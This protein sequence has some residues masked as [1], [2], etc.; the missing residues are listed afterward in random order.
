MKILS[1]DKK[2]KDYYYLKDE[3][4]NSYKLNIIFYDL[5]IEVN[6]GDIICINENYLNDKVLYFGSIKEE[7]G[8]RITRENVYDEIIVIQKGNEK[9]FLKRFYG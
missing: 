5:N 7:Y 2:D 4:N 8:K 9:Y 6:A 3:N 1:V